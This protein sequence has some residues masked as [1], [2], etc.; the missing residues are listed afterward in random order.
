MLHVHAQHTA[1]VA[2]AIGDHLCTSYVF[3]SNCYEC[4]NMTKSVPYYATNV[5]ARVEGVE[6][7]IVSYSN[8]ILYRKLL[9]CYL[10]S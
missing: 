9:V 3:Y 2:G 10:V 7:C 8:V 6:S 1:E 5:T 4:I